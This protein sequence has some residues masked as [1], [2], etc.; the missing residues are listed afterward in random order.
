M[1]LLTAHNLARSFGPDDIFD[2]ISVEV[3]QRAR[4]ALVGPNGAGKTT[5]VNIL[6]GQDLPT[7]GQVHRAKGLRIGFLPQ[8]PEL[9]GDHSL[10]EEALT[11]F[12][13]LRQMEARLH[14]LSERMADAPDDPQLIEAYGQ[15]Q[16]AF[17]HAGGYDYET[18]ARM[19]L[20]GVGF[21]PEQ[22]DMPLTQLSGGQK[23]RALLA[24]LLLEA[25]DLLVLDEP[26]NHLDIVAV[27]WLEHFLGSF[28]G[29]VL[30][31]SHDRYFMDRVAQVIWEMEWGTLEV[32]RGNYSHY[33]QQRQERHERLMKEFESQAAYIAKEEEYIRRHMAGQNTRQAQGRLKRL[34]TMRRNGRVLT[35]PRGKRREMN[36]KMRA[37]LRSGD[38]VLMTKGLRVGYPDKTLF[39]VPDITLYRGE[40]V[41]LIG[42]NGAGK[43]TFLKT[44]TGQLEA[45]AGQARMGASVKLGYFAQAH[46]LLDEKRSII[47]EITTAKP[48]LP[49]DARSYL[50]QF[51]F[52]G[53]DVHR[54]IASLS[55]GER[56]R[57]ALAKLALKG[58]NLLLLDEPTNHL[59]V[60]SQ[61]VLQSVLADFAGTVILVSHDRY[62]I[63]ALASQVWSLRQGEMQ[64]FEGPYAEFLADRAQRVEAEAAAQA[65]HTSPDTSPDAWP[66]ANG[67]SAADKPA[68]GLNPYQLKKRVAE[69]EESIHALEAELQQLE[70]DLAAASAAGDAARVSALGAAY[71]QAEARLDAVMEEWDALSA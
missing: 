59:D 62:L 47:D 65:P 26:T 1:A 55:G 35:R 58:A 28:P 68:H 18:R 50:A 9:H 10:W 16:A 36:L 52:T 51:L 38:K 33:L 45:L 42:P 66:P 34:E 17:E 6:I 15:L 37:A 5:L 49:A 8:R 67:K 60:D 20:T 46:E 64:V 71:T 61:E 57:V 40:T 69:L 2:G 70:S 39:D 7:E 44:V 32:Y 31:V 27:E 21:R 29:A 25:P 3:P 12:A 41:A 4:I 19:V 30:V 43:S 13:A 53:D 23:T 48:M 63:D 24:R 22:Y 11:G 56:G 14:D 54:P